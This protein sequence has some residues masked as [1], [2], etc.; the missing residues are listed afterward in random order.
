VPDRWG[1]LEQRAVIGHW[2]SFATSCESAQRLTMLGRDRS[3]NLAHA[4]RDGRIIFAGAAS[5][6]SP[7][8]PRLLGRRSRPRR[9]APTPIDSL[10]HA[11]LS[12]PRTMSDAVV[13]C[14]PRG[15]AQS[16]VTC[17]DRADAS[18]ATMKPCGADHLSGTRARRIGRDRCPSCR[19]A[20]LALVGDSRLALTFDMTPKDAFVFEACICCG[21]TRQLI[22]CACACQF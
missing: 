13:G 16:G 4:Q 14:T 3:W 10:T 8:W 15:T 1:S 9:E 12:K 11:Q 18:G 17:Q 5:I 19:A 21:L 20:H 22:D 2:R 7:S 6:S